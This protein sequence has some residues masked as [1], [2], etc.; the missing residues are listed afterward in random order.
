MQNV[1]DK[2]I[3]GSRL[4]QD[5]DKFCES[6][7][8]IWILDAGWYFGI[9]DR[10]S[11]PGVGCVD[12]TRRDPFISR[13]EIAAAAPNSREIQEKLKTFSNSL[14][15]FCVEMLPLVLLAYL[16]TARAY[17]WPSTQLD[18]LESAP[19]NQNGHNRQLIAAFIHPCNTFIFSGAGLGRSDVADWFR[20]LA[21][22]AYHDMATHNAEDGTGVWTRPFALIRSAPAENAGDGFS[23]TLAALMAQANRYVSINGLPSGGPEIAF[24]GGHVDAMECG[25][26]AVPEPDQLLNRTLPPVPARLNDTT[27]SDKRIF[28][29]DGNS[30]MQAGLFAR[31][32]DTVPRSVQL[33]EIIRP[34]PVKPTGIDL[35]LDGDVLNSRVKFGTLVLGYDCQ[36][37]TAPAIGGRYNAAWYQLNSTEDNAPFLSVDA[38][39]GIT[40][41]RFIV[42]NKL[43]DPGG[44][45]FTVQDGVVFSNSSCLTSRNPMQGRCAT[46]GAAAD[47]DAPYSVWSVALNNKFA[48]YN[49]EAI[50]DGAKIAW[51]A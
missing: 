42:D 8:K 39:A 13:M 50:V 11:P 2:A 31:A 22:E 12:R 17:F 40:S 24:R 23:N 48:T 7:T 41:M 29:S 26:P 30:T 46:E 3:S 32:L 4:A 35:V 9:S 49:V 18:A 28:A 25:P 15:S 27:N 14:D 36:P 6:V 20:N 37:P 5:T 43:E 45:G 34:F 21:G 47:P 10:S 51:T 38:V 16:A 1:P 44:L 19:W 33:T